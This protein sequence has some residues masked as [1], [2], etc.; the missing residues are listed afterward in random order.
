MYTPES[1]YHSERILKLLVKRMMVLMV[2]IIP[3]KRMTVMM[4]QMT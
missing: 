2:M 1:D 3:M 4:T